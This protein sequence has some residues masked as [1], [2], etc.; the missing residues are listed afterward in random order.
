MN[1]I[2]NYLNTNK[3]SA[4]NN[5]TQPKVQQTPVNSESMGKTIT[6]LSNVSPDYNVQKPIA[7]KQLGDIKLNDNLTAKYYK[8]ANGQR[9]VIVPKDGSTVVKSYVNTGSLNE[10]DNIRGISHYIEHNLFNG[11]EDLGDKVFFD[12][13]DKLGGGT[14]AS[15]S[16]DKTDYYIQSN[17]LE[18]T[19][20]E[21]QIQLHAGMLNSPKFMVDKLEKEKKIVNSEINMYMG[22]DE[23]LGHTQ[24]IKNL[25]NIKSSSLDLVA[26]TTDNITALT[27]EDVV[28]YYNNNYYPA[29]MTTVITGEVDPEET[30]KLVSKYFNREN[31]VTQARHYET[32]T[33]INNTI[34]QD[35][36]SSKSEGKA[37]IILGFA[38]PSNG[39]YK[40]SVLVQALNYIT[41]GLASSKVTDIE[42]KYGTGISIAKDRISS[43]V[44]D[45][46][47]LSV[48]TMV[49]D[50]NVEVV[51]KDIY[52]VISKMIQ[53]PPTEDELQAV[54]AK[55]KKQREQLFES[56]GALNNILGSA[57]LDNNEQDLNKYNEIVDSLTVNDIQNAAKKYYD[58]KKASLVVVH[59]RT[60]QA[61]QIMARYAQAAAGVNPA[62]VNQTGANVSF[63]GINKKAPIDVSKISTYRLSN[64]M[65]VLLNDSA[66]DVLEYR[67]ILQEKDWT[68]KEIAI[69]SVLGNMYS[70]CGTKSMSNKEIAQQKDRLAVSGGCSISQYGIS[71]GANFPSDSAKEVMK[72][73]VDQIKNPDLTKKDF[74]AAI[75]R[76]KLNWASIEPE[77][78]DNYDKVMY[79]GLPL[80]YTTKDYL[81]SLDNI[82]FEDVINFHKEILEKS[83]G[84]VVVTGPFSKK[85]EL[86]QEIFNSLSAFDMLQPKDIS[87][88]E[89]YK[90]IEK[91]QVYTVANMR[92]QA[93]IIQGYKFKQNG[94]LKDRVT[95]TLLNEIFG[96]SMSSRLFTDLRETRHLAYGVSSNIGYSED[97]GV[98]SLSIQTTTENKETGEKSYDNIKKAIDGFNENIKR[99]TT[100]KVTDE[101]LASAKKRMKTNLLNLIE[102]NKGKNYLLSRSVVTPYG[103]NYENEM[104]AMID[105]ITS[106]DLLT[107]AKYVFSGKPVYSLSATQESIDA[108]KEFLKSLEA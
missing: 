26:G 1:Y 45:P 65:E 42:K 98:M 82:K 47:L 31:K 85:P 53:T 11:S 39:D 89:I 105:S 19:D 59:P 79:Q 68:P 102:I 67:L 88:S 12:E 48:S 24:M 33:P 54:K 41:G 51:L 16:F 4:V 58:L 15:T 81:K 103:I 28:N 77:A 96:G 87:L 70:N 14:N 8:L 66:S 38:G 13:V 73:L 84:Q 63:T 64:N 30:I 23:S 40:E 101:E 76:L 21:T 9:V 25:F 80:M 50:E 29:N 17:L 34:R 93:D 6:E 90:P 49:P 91:A 35:I 74:D 99:I 7:Y 107:A 2:N 69:A 100:E 52:S 20:L 97:F 83:Q 55:L 86:K 75:A 72:T 106:E 46:T 94:N 22:Y 104:L 56:S 18:D 60:A 3:T 95:L 36:I 5:V 32:L 43:K 78:S 71:Y 37:T 57:L 10:T 27:R 108:N 62:T 61:D 92:N 44:G